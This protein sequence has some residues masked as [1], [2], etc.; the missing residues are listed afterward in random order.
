MVWGMARRRRTRCVWAGDVFFVGA[1]RPHKPRAGEAA[2]PD[3]C[4]ELEI[5]GVGINMRIC[6]MG[7]FEGLIKGGGNVRCG[8]AGFDGAEKVNAGQ[9]ARRSEPKN[10]SSMLQCPR[11]LYR[12]NNPVFIP[13][14]T[15][16]S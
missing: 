15:A 6:K 3:P 7:W 2:S 14:E 1:T 9:V 8:G 4:D 12:E 11:C 16:G 10:I 5:W 13:D